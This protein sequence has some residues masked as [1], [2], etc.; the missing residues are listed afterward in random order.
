MQGRQVLEVSSCRSKGQH[1]AGQTYD[2]RVLG[3]HIKSCGVVL[4]EVCDVGASSFEDGVDVY[5]PLVAQ[6]LCDVVPRAV[7]HRSTRLV[8]GI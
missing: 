3:R 8:Y 4:G 2:L 6:G 7:A 5:S 1:I